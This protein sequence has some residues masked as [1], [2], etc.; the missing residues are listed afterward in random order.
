MKIEKVIVPGI[1]LLVL[2]VSCLMFLSSRWGVG[3]THD[4]I[5]YLTSAWNFVTHNGLQW[6]ASDGSLHLLT[7][8]PP[9]YPLALGFLMAF[10]I[11]DVVAAT[12]LAALLFGLNVFTSGFLVY[13]FSRSAIWSIFTMIALAVSNPFVS[14]H[15]VALSEPLF[16]WLV[17]CGMGLI[18]LYFEKSKKNYLVIAALISGLAILTRY[19][20]IAMIATG[21]M[22]IVI[23]EKTP[24]RT[25]VINL[26]TY[27]TLSLAPLLMWAVRNRL[28]DGSTTNRTF[29]FH[30][31]DWGNRKLGFE[32]IAD[33][34]T[35]SPAPYNETIAITGLFLLVLFSSCAWLGWK[36]AF[37]KNL[38]TDQSGG[39][40]LGFMFTLFSLIYLM[41]LLA[42]LTF[43]DASTRLDGRILAPV[44][45]SSL[46]AFFLI[47]GGLSPGWQ[48]AGGVV[49]LLLLSLHLPATINSSSDFRANGIGFSGKN[50]IE[51]QV[52]AYVR[53]NAGDNI[54]YSNQGLAL[55]FLTGKK[56]LEIPEKMDV[57]RNTARDDYPARMKEMAANLENPGSFIVWFAGGG[58][59]DSILNDAE[60]DLHVYKEYPEA[61]I[62]ASSENLRNGSLP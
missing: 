48:W 43:F 18:G 57:V 42:S 50:W 53:D 16:I 38:K 2:S 47:L 15:F 12:W 23:I 9:L 62:L 22:A 39:F 7:H 34:F 51:S 49:F 45:V 46:I 26:L 6:S 31:L 60:I 20:G 52:I 33:W 59:S 29:I 5:F 24:L 27:L 41:I 11:P 21:L 25:K 35:W 44:Y 13:R 58:L 10:G 28:L 8:F 37:S 40:R 32:T 14:L 36:L 55:H 30:P 1:L 3:V 4:S 54:I 61:D 17:M 56:V 19:I